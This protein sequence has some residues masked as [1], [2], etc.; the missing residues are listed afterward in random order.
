[1]EGEVVARSCKINQNPAKPEFFFCIFTHPGLYELA[2]ACRSFLNAD[3]N[4]YPIQ[5]MK[6]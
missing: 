6:F 4:S 1:M 5:I 2:T 3:Q